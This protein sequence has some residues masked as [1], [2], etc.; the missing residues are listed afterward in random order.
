MPKRTHLL[1]RTAAALVALALFASPARAD[2][3]AYNAAVL[4]G[5]F[6]AAAS[7]AAAT[8]PTLDK[9]RPDI[10]VIGREFGWT[11]MLAKKPDIARTI[12]SSLS[13]SAAADAMPEVTAVLLTWATF[14]N[15]PGNDTRKALAEALAARAKTPTSELISIR[16][17][18]DLFSYEWARDNFDDAAGIAAIGR[19]LVTQFGEEMVDVRF[20]MRR[21]E[22][23]SR[24]VDKPKRTDITTISELVKEIDARLAVETDPKLRSALIGQLATTIAWRGVEQNVL[25]FGG[26]NPTGGGAESREEAS[27]IRAAWFPV[28]GDPSTPVCALGLDMGGVK[29]KYPKQ[30][31]TKR[32]PG[33]AVY[34]FDIDAGGKFKSA[35]VLGS[36][37][38]DMFTETIDDIL[39]AWKWRKR[40]DPPGGCRMPTVLVVDFAFEIKRR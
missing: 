40:Q 14:S 39:P 32:L 35:R 36:A 38:H 31:M 9:A 5:D 34:A 17:A 1:T 3:K 30:A 25:E 4:K 12:V 8:W 21:N 19:Q 23:V 18:Q 15:K 2:I 26:V 20:A 24:F 13:Q 28:P 22:I 11:A 6:T 7:E 33:Y 37:P 10:F 27:R 29:P 16:A